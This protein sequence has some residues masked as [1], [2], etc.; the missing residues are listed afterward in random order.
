[1]IL[2]ESLKLIERIKLNTNL[3]IWDNVHY[4]NKN[5]NRIEGRGY[6]LGSQVVPILLTVY[7]FQPSTGGIVQMKENAQ[8]NRR[9]SAACLTPKRTFSKGRQITKKRSKARIAKD[10]SA[11]IPTRQKVCYILY[12]L[13]LVIYRKEAFRHESK[14]HN[15]AKIK[16]MGW[17]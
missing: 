17:H 6:Q 5:E 7:L 9:P 10:Q 12:C 8:T 16:F 14:Q 4:T 3:I 2:I 15:Y 13:L 1:M 11:T